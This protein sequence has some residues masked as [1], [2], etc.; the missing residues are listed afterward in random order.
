MTSPEGD[1]LWTLDCLSA[2]TGLRQVVHDIKSCGESLAGVLHCEARVTE[3]PPTLADCYL[4]NQT[5]RKF[6]RYRTLWMQGQLNPHI[7]L[8][9]GYL[10][11]VCQI[12]FPVPIRKGTEAPCASWAVRGA[13]RRAGW[14]VPP[15]VHR[16]GS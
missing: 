6:D 9:D 11:I 3:C 14:G 8:A 15:G 2:M 4:D 10:D 13:G 7:T 5:Y 12:L 1:C 16:L